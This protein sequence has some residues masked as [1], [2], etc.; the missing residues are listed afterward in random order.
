MQS[1]KALIYSFIRLFGASSPI[2][3]VP[4]E[5][6]PI[7][8]DEEIDLL[9][10]MEEYGQSIGLE[11]QVP[12]N[13][14]LCVENAEISGQKESISRMSIVVAKSY[15]VLDVLEEAESLH[16]LASNYLAQGQYLQAEKLY[17]HS[18]AIREKLLGYSHPKVAESLHNL[19][20]ICLKNGLYSKAETLFNN[21]LEIRELAFGPEHSKVAE[22]LC[23]LA[24]V[25]AT[26]GR[27]GMAESFYK[28]ALVIREKV[29]DINNQV[30]E[31]TSE[32]V[33][34]LH[35]FQIRNS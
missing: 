24:S 17:Q 12:D 14:V 15:P 8:T 28:R 11:E 1:F 23:E 4:Y 34:L 26:T 3:F 5:E 32:N 16:H 25:F 7:A 20:L 13:Q 6:L 33:A 35:A 31:I 18:L 29:F 9:N 27:Y 10:C 22:S 30:W 19:A 21:S 2:D